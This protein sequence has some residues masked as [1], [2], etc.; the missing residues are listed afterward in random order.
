MQQVRDETLQFARQP[1]WLIGSFAGVASLLAALGLYGVLSYMVTQRRR[2]LGIRIALGAKPGD[3]LSLIMRSG[4]GMIVVGL[5]LGLAGSVSLTRVLES[6]LFE[7]KANDPVTLAISCTATLAVGL[8]A[9][10]LPA[11]RAVR[12]PPVEVLREA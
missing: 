5:V 11:A 10:L 9:G 7:V 4:L 2:E 8:C 6:L 12:V 3:V 1:A